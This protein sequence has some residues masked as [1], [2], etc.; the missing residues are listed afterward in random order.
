MNRNVVIHAVTVVVAATVFSGVLRAQSASEPRVF[1]LSAKTLVDQKRKVADPKDAS[2]KPAL[3]KIERDAQKALKEDVLSIVTKTATPPSGDKHDYMTQAPYFWKN[4]DTKDG[5]PYIQRDGERNPEI[6][7][8][9]D[10]EL[11]DNMDRAVEHL[12]TAYFFTGKEE[13][14]AKAAEILRMWFVDPKTKMN[15][16]LD[17]AQ[18]VPGKNTGRGIGIIETRQLARVVDAIGL[19]NGAKSWTKTDQANVETW[20]TAY[21]KWLMTSKNGLDESKATNNHGT[22]YDVQVISFALFTHQMDLAK[23]VLESAKQDRIAKQIEPNGG[24]P[25]ELARTKSWSYSTMNLDGM[26]ELAQL[27][28]AAG[29]DLWGFQTSDGR[30]IRKAIDFLFPYG[31]GDTKWTL[32][33]IEAFEPERLYTTMRVASRAYHDDSYN[34]M[35]ARVPKLAAD[36]GRQLLMF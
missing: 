10:H 28:D 15:P 3:A 20:F 32:Q 31:V 19:L 22:F 12:A 35:M 14:A 30:S 6:K 21:L 11:L 17:F 4:P 13:Y 1:L 36:D 2:L 34:K 33:Q 9:P 29:V 24:Q 18:A 27:G 16:D 26:V 8:Y 5:L 23:K 25:R 7:Q